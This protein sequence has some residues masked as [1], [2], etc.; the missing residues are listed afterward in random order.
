MRCDCVCRYDLAWLVVYIGLLLV[1]FFADFI[2]CVLR[3]SW[4]GACLWFELILVGG[5]YV[6]L[7]FACNCDLL[8]DYNVNSVVHWHTILL[9]VFIYL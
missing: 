9:F 2:V 3:A 5:F 1:V 6:D 8:F 7:L 4:V